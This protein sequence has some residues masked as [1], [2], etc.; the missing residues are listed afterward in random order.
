[1]DDPRGGLASVWSLAARQEHAAIF[2]R[3]CP[4]EGAE[5]PKEVQKVVYTN[6][7]VSKFSGVNVRRL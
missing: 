2:P 3:F 5:R 6:R 4:T 7:N 1:M